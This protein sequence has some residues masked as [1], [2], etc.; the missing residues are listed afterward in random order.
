MHL[1]IAAAGI[2]YGAGIIGWIILGAIA[3]WLAGMFMKG[4]GYG[5][6][7]DIIVGI[8][9]ALVGGFVLSLFGLGANGFIGTLITAFIGACILIAI[10][11]AVAGGGTRRTA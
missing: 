3:G 2:N 5:L 1:V 11:R 10:V 9:G 7:G 6:I 4:G 8:V